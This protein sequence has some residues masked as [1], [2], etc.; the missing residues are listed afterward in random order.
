MLGPDQK[1]EEVGY[2]DNCTKLNVLSIGNNKIASF[3]VITSYF[4]SK[5]NTMKF[6]FLQVLNVAGN[7]FT[8]EPDYKNYI[9]S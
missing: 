9:I 4:A 3:D 5:N 6:K 2:L 8:K 1:P 7:P